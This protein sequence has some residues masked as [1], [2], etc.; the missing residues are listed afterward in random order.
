MPA[1]Q[2]R[3]MATQNFATV[4]TAMSLLQEVGPNSFFCLP[5]PM[6]IDG[7]YGRPYQ[8]HNSSA[9]SSDPL[10]RACCRVCFGR[11]HGSIIVVNNAVARDQEVDV[12][13]QLGLGI[14]LL[15][16]QTHM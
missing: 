4:V 8:A 10:I 2:R 12:P 14:R 11:S 13:T 16:G 9:F 5:C 1:E 6:L 3:A 7:L 15:Q